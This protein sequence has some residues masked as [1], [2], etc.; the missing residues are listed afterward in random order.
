MHTMTGTA[1]TPLTAEQYLAREHLDRVRSASRLTARL[2][3]ARLT[4]DLVRLERW[5]QGGEV[6]TSTSE[7]P[8]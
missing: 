7:R 5:A 1:A 2:T 6:W 8:A 4:A 3:R